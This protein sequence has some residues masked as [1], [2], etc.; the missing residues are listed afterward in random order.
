MS[1]RK[2]TSS[3]VSYLDGTTGMAQPYAVLNSA[4]PP[5]LRQW[6]RQRRRRWGSRL[7]AETKGSARPCR[8]ERPCVR[9]SI[10]TSSSE[11]ALGSSSHIRWGRFPQNF[12]MHSKYP[13][14][15]SSWTAWEPETA[16]GRWK[17]A[18]LGI[19]SVNPSPPPGQTQSSSAERRAH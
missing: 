10:V 14:T 12:C 9:G 5:H 17:L 6:H 11:S 4:V 7:R 19:W 2:C 3:F 1:E 8:I 15:E 18:K 16:L 13:Y